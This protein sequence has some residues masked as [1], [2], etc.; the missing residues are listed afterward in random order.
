MSEN[1]PVERR[2]LWQRRIQPVSL[3]GRF[4]QYFVV[5]SHYRFTTV[6]G[7]KCDDWLREP[8]GS[9]LFDWMRVVYCV[10]YTLARRTESGVWTP[11]RRTPRVFCG[12]GVQKVYLSVEAERRRSP[13]FFVIFF[14]NLKLMCASI[15][16]ARFH[17]GFA[18]LTQ[19]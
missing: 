5:K 6:R 2:H 16:L 1:P 18:L 11:Q 7:K 10:A 4:H 13:L 15:F 14:A 12:C 19:H 8:S 17:G 3:G 9:V